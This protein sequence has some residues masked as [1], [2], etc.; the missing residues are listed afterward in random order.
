MCAQAA[1]RE[2]DAA[3]EALKEGWAAELRRQRRDWAAAEEARRGT[4]VAQKTRDIKELTAK[5]NAGWHFC[6]RPSGR[7][8]TASYGRL[9]FGCCEWDGVNGKLSRLCLTALITGSWHR[10][11]HWSYLDSGFSPAWA[12]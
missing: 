4:W 5:V 6:L 12:L 3:V 1:A 7:G 11:G 2:H 9:S 8:R 10:V